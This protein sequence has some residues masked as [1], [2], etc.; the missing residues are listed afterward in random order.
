MLSIFGALGR[1]MRDLAHPRILAVLVAPMLGAIVLW[2]VLA[3][4][5]WDAWT[6]AFKAMVEDTGIARWLV[7]QGAAWMLEGTGV[8]VVI[9]AL[10]P[11]VLITA[12]LATRGAAI[13]AW[14]SGRA[15]RRSGAS[16]TRAWRS[17]RSRVCGS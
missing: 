17:A 14:R 15:E 13:R 7:A 12:V 4:L 11:A 6:G 16:R 8:I 2:S 1:A 9:V 3:G 10:V 5:F